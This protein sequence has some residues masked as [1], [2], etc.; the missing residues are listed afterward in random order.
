MCAISATCEEGRVHVCYAPH[1]TA[2]HAR[3]SMLLAMGQAAIRLRPPRWKPSTSRLAA[4]LQPSIV[5]SSVHPDNLSSSSSASLFPQ[6]GRHLTGSRRKVNDDMM[7]VKVESGSGQ[8]SDR[9]SQ[10]AAPQ[11]HLEPRE[12]SLLTDLDAGEATMSSRS[13]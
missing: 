2:P 6:G 8:G 1:Q 12:A 11:P 5:S 7:N 13:E 9:K 4:Q 3:L 10:M